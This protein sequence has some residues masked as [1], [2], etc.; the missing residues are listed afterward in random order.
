[1]GNL[2]LIAPQDAKTLAGLF[3]E[4]TRRSPDKIAY[5]YFREE[6]GSWQECTW[7]EVSEWAARWQQTMTKE[8]LQ[9]GDRV[10]VMLRNCLEWVLFDLAASG[11][12]LVTVPLYVNDRPENFTYILQSTEARLLLTDG[13]EQ[14]QR[15]EEVGDK[16]SGI[17]RIVTLQTVCK[18]DC[19]PRLRQL[20]DWLLGVE[21]DQYIQQTSDPHSL[22]TIVFTS[23]TTGPPKG[24]MLS[25]D[26]MIQ[27]AA[28][29]LERVAVYTDDQ[30]LS[31]LPLSHMLERTAGYYISIMAGSCIAFVRSIDL[32]AEDLLTI[33]PTILVTVPRI[34]ERI[35][36]KMILKLKDESWLAR[37]IFHL[38]VKSGWHHFQYH[39]N[40]EPW[41]I[42]LLIWPLLKRIVGTKVEQRLGGRLRMAIS[43]GAPLSTPIAQTFIGL[44]ITILQGY[45]LT[46][47]S[48]IISVNT[49]EDNQPLSV[50][51][52][53]PGV[54]VKIGENKE[55]LVK[56]PNLMLG[57]WKMDQS[58]IDGDGW[59][60]TGDQARIDK[61]GRIH[62]IGRTKEIIVLSS[63][64]KVPPEDLQL[65]IATDP[66]FEQVLV[67]GE[68]RPSL[69]AIV[70]VNPSQWKIL[71]NKLGINAGDMSQLNSPQVKKILLDKIGYRLKGFPG[72]AKIHRVHATT[73][74]WDID[75][76]L[77]TATLKVRREPIVEQ[78]SSEIEEL[79][80]EGGRSNEA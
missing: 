10:A 51:R 72:Y 5:R 1:M 76:G 75:S 18:V 32:L 60:H 26:N 43:G 4:R 9:A 67:V 77:I 53:L 30:M 55:L 14:W 39:R 59:L 73:E 35:Y 65:A 44:G 62:I 12:G 36:N 2:D 24:V 11:L 6:T 54:E 52:P 45:G 19:D 71:A 50:G 80:V 31:F 25:H 21:A 3:A 41:A 79:Y 57:Y 46:E 28:A 40:R 61:K 38:A 58:I 49:L 23:G 78:F 74:S 63:G 33:R 70:V 8:G 27:N 68:N 13:P 69:A 16:L 15:I 29:G 37:Q 22:A 34:F 17:E 56:G 7:R 66:L 42:Q 48:P 64:E 47:T 20:D